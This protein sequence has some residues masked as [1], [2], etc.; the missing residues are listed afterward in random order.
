MCDL[1]V[2][3]L[4][5]IC[6]S[7]PHGLPGHSQTSC[8]DCRKQFLLTLAC[9]QA[10][11]FCTGP[12]TCRLP[13]TLKIHGCL[14]LRCGQVRPQRKRSPMEGHVGHLIIRACYNAHPSRTP[15]NNVLEFTSELDPNSMTCCRSDNS[16]MFQRLLECLQKPYLC[17]K[18]QL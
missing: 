18:Q 2:S 15:P 12:P 8:H 13:V 6:P 4:G 5:A 9:C 17:C 14:S 10:G 16:N 11:L 7:L 3:G 1:Q